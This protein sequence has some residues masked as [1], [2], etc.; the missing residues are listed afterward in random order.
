MFF[1]FH[2]HIQSNYEVRKSVKLLLPGFKTQIKFVSNR[3]KK[4]TA[5]CFISADIQCHWFTFSRVHSLRASE[6]VFKDLHFTS[7]L[8][9]VC[10]V[11]PVAQPPEPNLTPPTPLTFHCQHTT[12][13]PSVWRC[14]PLHRSSLAASRLTRWVV[15]CLTGR[16]VGSGLVMILY[17][18]LVSGRW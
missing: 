2:F 3:S 17:L 6:W 12:P 1:L 18:S 7:H 11:L 4:N 10:L 13:P 14:L 16:P 15:L 9:C 8:D 5:E